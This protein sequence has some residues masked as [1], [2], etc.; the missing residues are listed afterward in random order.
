VT[1][2]DSGAPRHPEIER[3]V[4]QT[5]IVK[6]GVLRCPTEHRTFKDPGPTQNFVLVFPRTPVLIHRGDGI[7]FVADP[8]VVS[9]WN[10]RQPY[11]REALGSEGAVSDWFAIQH[12]VVVD[13]VRSFDTSVE[14]TPDK[15]FRFSHGPINPRLYLFQRQLLRTILQGAEETLLIEEAIINML[16][17]AL[18]GVYSLRRSDAPTGWS[19]DDSTEHDVVLQAE[20]A[21]ARQFR[22]PLSLKKIAA[23]VG[24]SAFH[25]C[26]LFKKARGLTLH[27]YQTQLRL[28]TALDY[29]LDTRRDL[30]ELSF[31]LG[32]SSHSHFT[33]TFRH[34]F[35]MTPSAARA[36]RPRILRT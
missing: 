36:Q 33:S 35:G 20:A 34:E 7:K 32:F 12:D 10:A 24:S 5:D 28:R 30:T 6:V 25:L 8:S 4:F 18:A 16:F 14:R 27:A 22:D 26:R 1:K 3:V 2:K 21:V 9:F 15:P 29:V 13:A 31:D 17:R 19:S 23:E 11:L